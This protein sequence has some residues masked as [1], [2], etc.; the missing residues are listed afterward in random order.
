MGTCGFNAAPGGDT[1]IADGAEKLCAEAVFE[2]SS[3]E[4]SG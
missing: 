3:E 1:V 2:Q 4:K